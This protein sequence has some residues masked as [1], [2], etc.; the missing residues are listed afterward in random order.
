VKL[1]GAGGGFSYGNQ[2]VSHN[3]T[4]D[5]S[6]VRNLP[7]ITMF[8]P[9]TKTEVSIAFD[10]MIKLKGPSF[11]RLGKAPEKILLKTNS[12]YSIG[13]GVVAK[14]GHD[15]VI[16][17]VGNIIKDVI[18]A[19][20]KLDK[21]GISTK[22]IS[23]LTIKPI[24]KDNI[25]KLTKTFKSIFTVEEH[26][27]FGGIGTI[28]SEILAESTNLNIFFRRIGINDENILE[29]GTQ[30]YL[31]EINGLSSEGIMNQIKVYL[32]K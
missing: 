1:V 3:S 12:N 31:K 21:L 32:N 15:I 23:F 19:A 26:N 27:K 17:C 10:F 4:E 11:I 13:D 29:I 6:V 20:D 5:L 16:I 18:D 14:D 9:G 7:N 24:N 30:K 25:L 2:G 22:V 8:S 28:V